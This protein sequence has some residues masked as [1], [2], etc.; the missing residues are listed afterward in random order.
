MAMISWLVSARSSQA[1]YCWQCVSIS[2]FRKVSVSVPDLG[3]LHQISRNVWR[4]HFLNRPR[5]LL[6]PTWLFSVFALAWLCSV[7]RFTALQF[8]QSGVGHPSSEPFIRA[9]CVRALFFRRASTCQIWGGWE[10]WSSGIWRLCRVVRP[11]RRFEGSYFP[12]RR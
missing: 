4:L 1:W 3:R 11:Y 2:M 8:V 10:S 5:L 9:I 12:Q 7:S 6:H